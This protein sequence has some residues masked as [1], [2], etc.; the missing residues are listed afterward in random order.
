MNDQSSTDEKEAPATSTALQARRSGLCPTTRRPTT[1]TSLATA[2]PRE[3][4]ASGN[5]NGDNGRVV[6]VPVG[7]DLDNDDEVTR[8]G[9]AGNDAEIKAGGHLDSARQIAASAVW[10]ATVEVAAAGAACEA[11][12]NAGPVASSRAASA[13]LAKLL[14]SKP[15]HARGTESPASAAMDDA[16]SASTAVLQAVAA[17]PVLP[18]RPPAPNDGDEGAAAPPAD[19]DTKADA[20]ALVACRRLC[21][22]ARRAGGSVLSAVKGLISMVQPDAGDHAGDDDGSGNGGDAGGDPGDTAR[23]GGGTRGRQRR[24]GGCGA[25]GHYVRTCPADSAAKAAHAERGEAAK[26]AKGAKAGSGK[27]KCSACHA[28]GHTRTSAVCPLQAVAHGW[29]GHN[30]GRGRDLG[31]LDRHRMTRVVTTTASVSVGRFVGVQRR[32]APGRPADSLLPTGRP[33][34]TA[35]RCAPTGTADA[36]ANAAAGAVALTELATV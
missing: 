29:S 12:G 8:L 4:T 24:C 22:R 21:A 10:S 14:A 1:T 35:S 6:A 23:G 18:P 13:L 28:R 30:A 26:A 20:S 34:T 11:A 31:C 27:N 17:V 36:V 16:T 3:A 25:T 2:P 32:L 7:A 15:V 19:A 5:D 33:P 9:T